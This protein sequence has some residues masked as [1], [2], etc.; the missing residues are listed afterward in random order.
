MLSLKLVIGAI[1]ILCVSGFPA[2]LFS[3]KSQFGQYITVFLSVAGS[4]LG[5]CG[6]GLA[7]KA[8]S[9]AVLQTKWALPWGQF[10]VGIDSLNLVFLI[11]I[12]VIPLLGSIYSLEYWNQSKHPENGKKLG[13]F[14]G[15]LAGTMALVVIAKDSVLFLIAW[16]IMA[17]SAFFAATVEDENT[18]VRQAGWVYLI[19]THIGTLCLFA[20]FVLWNQCTG[21]FELDPVGKISSKAGSA[22]FV[23]ALI[24]F[25]F[26]A[27][28]MPLHVWLPGAHA[29]APSHVSALMSG[30]M[31]KM[32]IYGIMRM[33]FLMP[34]TNLWWG[35]VLLVV[36]V[37]SGIAGIAFAI[38]Q[39]DIKRVLAYSSIE[40]IGIICIAL[41]LALLGRFQ[42]RADWI[43]LGLGG[44]LL[45][46]LNHGL[47]KSLLF[48]NAGAVIHAVHTRDINLMGGLA[49]KMPYTML[50]FFLGAIAICA[51]PPLNGF[52]SEWFIYAGLFRTILNE[53]GQVLPFAALGAVALAMIGP[54]AIA[55]FVKL[56]GAVFLGNPRNDADLH[57]K[58]PS[59]GMLIPMSILALSCLVIGV[60]PLFLVDVLKN[61]TKLWAGI[62][63]VSIS[64]V[65]FVPLQ[66]ISV[67]AAV[68]FFSILLIVTL[69][70]LWPEPKSTVG[71]W[72]CGYA[73]PSNKMQY[74]G[75]SFGDSL[76][77]LFSFILWPANQKPGITGVFPRKVSYKSIVTDTILDRLVFPVFRVAGRYLPMVRFFQ[78]GQT[79]AYVLYILVII[80]VLLILGI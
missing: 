28:I 13:L 58:E 76:V 67:I 54:M 32:G 61:A 9:L 18:N 74:T 62:S 47:F 21:S 7:V 23:L 59:H 1:A 52:I 14:F 24:G 77:K 39:N 15:L 22:L 44:A 17:L 26:K 8:N 65:S 64:V 53:T 80:I 25:G 11:L 63:E 73:N 43:Y 78:R 40:N 6:V 16:E 37:I 57:A 31:L 36:G 50:F 3:S 56:A 34:V 4:L 46:V 68:L 20:M 48:F 51:L 35:S 38:G 75:S 19:A 66:L 41:G 5:L 45:H 30:V 79:H 60:F 12:F 69:F 72:D 33:T 70:R 27:G 49:K 29:N 42:G 55:C 71:T 2:L 10:S